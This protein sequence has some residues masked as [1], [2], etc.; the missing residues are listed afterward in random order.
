MAV[1]TGD[2]WRFERTHI[3]AVMTVAEDAFA[4]GVACSTDD[5]AC[6]SAQRTA[7]AEASLAEYV[8]DVRATCS[9]AVMRLPGERIKSFMLIYIALTKY[10]LFARKSTYSSTSSKYQH[11]KTRNSL[12]SLRLDSF[13]SEIFK[14]TCQLQFSV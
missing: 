3:L 6:R 1:C 7:A 2:N 5:S 4:F 8:L 11:Q 13:Q 12:Y 10:N 14:T 9:A